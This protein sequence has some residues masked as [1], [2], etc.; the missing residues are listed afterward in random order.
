[1]FPLALPYHFAQ[2]PP[3]IPFLYDQMLRNAR[4]GRG[5]RRDLGFFS[6]T[7]IRMVRYGMEL[8][9]TS[10][11]PPS[12]PPSPWAVVKSGAPSL[13]LPSGGCANTKLGRD[14]G[15]IIYP[16]DPLWSTQPRLEE[17]QQRKEGG[18]RILGGGVRGRRRRIWGCVLLPR[19]LLVLI[20]A[21]LTSSSS[22]PLL[23]ILVILLFL[24]LVFKRKR[25]RMM[26]A[27]QRMVLVPWPLY[28]EETTNRGFLN[29]QVPERI[30][31]CRSIRSIMSDQVTKYKSHSGLEDSTARLLKR[32]CS[33][34]FQVTYYRT[35]FCLQKQEVHKWPSLIKIESTVICYVS[36]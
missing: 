5:K 17:Q 11:P 2:V 21:S 23:L 31:G 33:I 19:I 28:S 32:F 27:A 15:S 16:N 10:G 35:D 26:Q 6:P 4:G 14:Q 30:G 22:F 8:W 13:K 7:V 24:L 1:M 34:I 25:R 9:H 18:K 12:P 3:G 20:L 29:S 36:E